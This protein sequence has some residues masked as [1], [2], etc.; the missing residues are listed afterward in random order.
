MI[1]RRVLLKRA[2]GAAL[3]AGLPAAAAAAVDPR[4]LPPQIGDELAYP[5]W[6][7]DERLIAPDEVV[8]NAAP[9]LAYPRDP[10][11]RVARERSRLNQILL[12][13]FDHAELDEATRAQSADG[14]V[15]YSGVCTHT[16]C[17]VSE[18]NDAA[19]HFVCPCHGSEFD[20]RKHATI[21]GGPATRPLPGL[22]IALDNGILTVSGPFTA[23]VG[24]DET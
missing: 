2:M 21:I 13:H 16:A 3:Y 11:T 20:P 8:R 4:K 7:H 23:K 1:D 24:A 12:V 18:W 10:T 22:P 14:I 19:G 15:A 9:I 5:S 17:G 6:E